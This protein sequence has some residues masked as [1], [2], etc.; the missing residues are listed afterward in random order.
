MQSRRWCH[1]LKKDR[2]PVPAKEWN[3]AEKKDKDDLSRGEKVSWS[4]H[5]QDVPGRVKKK[6][7]ERTVHRHLAQRPGGDV[8]GT[9]CVTRS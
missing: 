9:T 1:N 4:S 3:V 8:T 7:T 5:G 6:I 2:P